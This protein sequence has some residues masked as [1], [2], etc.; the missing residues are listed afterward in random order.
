MRG[1][2]T[3]TTTRLEAHKQF[4]RRHFEEVW[5]DGDVGRIDETYAD[6]WIGY[7]FA[8]GA[9]GLD[10]LK[11]FVGGYPKAFPEFH[12]DVETQIAE[13]DEVLTRFTMTGTHKGEIMGIES[14]EPKSR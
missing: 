13:A 12:F 7:G 9:I 5:N 6:D 14:P 10:G 2:E 8:E 3:S 11:G 4:A 1:H